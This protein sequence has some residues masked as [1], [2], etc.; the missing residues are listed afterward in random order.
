[1]IGFGSQNKLF[2]LFSTLDISY[3]SKKNNEK[4]GPQINIYLEKMLIQHRI[5]NSWAKI[6]QDEKIVGFS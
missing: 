5:V 1:V 3:F 2:V 6:I 4:F